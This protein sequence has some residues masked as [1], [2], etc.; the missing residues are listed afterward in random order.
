MANRAFMNFGRTF[1]NHKDPATI[2]CQFVVDNT[3]AS[4]IS[5]LKSNGYV[6]AIYMNSAAMSPDTPNPAAGIIAVQL[7]D[8]YFSFI[9]ANYTGGAPNSGSNLSTKTADAALTAGTPYVITVL[10]TN[11][12]ADWQAC[13]LPAG[14]TPAIGMTFIAANTGAAG[15]HTG[16]VQAV[17]P[18]NC[19]SIELIGNPNS[20]LGPQ[21]IQNQGGWLFFQCMKNGAVATPAPG[22]T[23]Y[24]SMELNT[25]SVTVDG[26]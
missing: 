26:E 22:T 11:T 6:K 3:Q 9:Q 7:T 10:G 2:D 20:E 18:T 23:F 8:N 13:G 14:L 12:L 24:L 25:S 17:I 15:T 19:D 1:T 21:N 5:G 16:Q 4:G